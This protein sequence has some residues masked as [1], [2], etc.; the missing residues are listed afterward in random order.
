M[1]KK[2]HSQVLNYNKSF[3][4]YLEGKCLFKNLNQEEFDVIWKRIY[5]SYWGDV[6]S[7]TE[8]DIDQVALIDSSF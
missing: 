1:S 6:F 5:H 3:H 8:I 7:Y 2:I 4:I